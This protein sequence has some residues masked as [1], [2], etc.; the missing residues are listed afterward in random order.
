ME[1]NNRSIRDG[2]VQY[3]GSDAPTPTDDPAAVE[4]ALVAFV[5]DRVEAAGAAGV[6]VAMSGGLDSTVT[7]ALAVEALGSDRV[8]GLALPCHKTDASAAMEAGAVADHLDIDF[9][10]VHLRPLLHQF[11]Q[12]VA[13]LLDPEET[14]E[15]TPTVD[16]ALGNAVARFRMVCAYYAANRTNRLV[17]GTAN[18]SELLLGYL[19]K[20]GDGAADL[21]PL[22]DL[23]K[24]E[25]RD[26]AEHL[27]VPER[28]VEAEPTAGDYPAQ[29]DAADLGAPYETIDPFLERLVDRG[30]PTA[31]AAEGL[32]LDSE[33]AERL[34]RMYR[35]S[36]H[37]RAVP[38]TPGLS[39]RSRRPSS[40][41]RK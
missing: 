9:E 3:S 31:A 22:G 13:P 19:T 18:R 39:G 7:V 1:G 2:D 11:D 37:K 36:A 27:G 33:T 17:L 8:L 38:P 16:R 29:T 24:T 14:D 20:Y 35:Q 10:R 30:L 5:R 4:S 28:I 25:V 12:S 6:V 40:F 41:S 34:A 26:L 15:T 32:D 21:C 23:Y